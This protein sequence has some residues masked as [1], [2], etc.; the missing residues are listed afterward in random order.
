MKEMK[1]S[2]KTFWYEKVCADKFEKGACAFRVKDEEGD[3]N[4][5]VVVPPTLTAQLEG[6]P[7]NCPDDGHI[8]A[9]CMNEQDALMIA[10]SVCIAASVASFSKDA[11]D[12]AKSE[13][14]RKTNE[15]ANKMGFDLEKL[16]AEVKRLKAEGKS[17]KE[18]A[19]ILKPRMEE[20][21]K[22]DTPQSDTK[23][24]EW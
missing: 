7:I 12:K 3:E 19:A 18:V 8:A 4:W 2:G 10:S 6:M 5:W 22:S 15:L 20:F 17:P 9:F 16:E 1:M 14:E 21:K 11:I 24:G 13:V 23:G